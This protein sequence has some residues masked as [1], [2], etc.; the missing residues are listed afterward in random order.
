MRPCSCG[1]EHAEY[2]TGTTPVEATLGEK[3]TLTEGL[4]M[5]L[6]TVLGSW[7]KS[8]SRSH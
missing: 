3:E 2:P 6:I 8:V 4:S 1:G 7:E 5:V